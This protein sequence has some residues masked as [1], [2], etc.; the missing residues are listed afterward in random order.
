MR[1]D[2]IILGVSAVVVAATVMALTACGDDSETPAADGGQ[3]P[4]AEGGDMTEGL[5]PVSGETVTTDSGLQYIDIEEGTGDTPQGGQTVVAH[6]TGWLED[7]TKF[8]SSVD[9]GTP[10]T[11]TLGVGQVIAGW[12]EGLATMKVGGQRRLIIPP[13]LGYGETGA[14]AT[15]PPNATLIFDVELLEIR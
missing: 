3:T 8:D 15:I 10:L 7:G 6:Y 11:F 4:T 9:R 2:G 5:P 13:D 14:G 1:R 12:D